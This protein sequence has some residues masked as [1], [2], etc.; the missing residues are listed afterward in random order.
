MIKNQGK[1][2]K[3]IPGV[4]SVFPKEQPSAKSQKSH[5]KHQVYLIERK[6]NSI[7]I[8]WEYHHKR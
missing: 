2:H 5:N 6:L 7:H 4:W 1:F 8:Y 3:F